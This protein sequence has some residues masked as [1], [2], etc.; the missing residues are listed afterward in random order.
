MEISKNGATLTNDQIQVA[1]TL[2]YGGSLT[3]TNLGS[4]A[5]AAGDR[6]QLFSAAPFAGTFATIALPPLGTGLAWVNN[7]L[8]DGS[9]EIVAARQPGFASIRL[10]GGNVILAGTNGTANAT[11]TV[12]AATN[13]ALP[14]ANW[15]SLA[16]NRFDASGHFSFTNLIVPEIPQRFFQLRTP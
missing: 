12:L 4:T 10:S 16:T 14:V 3:V 8:V 15:V 1:G 11:Y 2:T 5:L 6:F 9:I 13:V 7:L